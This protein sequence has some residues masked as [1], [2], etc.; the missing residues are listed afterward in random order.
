[1]YEVVRNRMQQYLDKKPE[2]L[3]SVGK[4]GRADK[5]KELKEECSD[6]T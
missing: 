3:E 6:I 4:H 5:N 1:M 2:C